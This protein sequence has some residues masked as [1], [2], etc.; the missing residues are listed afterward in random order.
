MH[1]KCAFL[2][3]DLDENIYMKQLDGYEVLR[4]KNLVYK[5]KKTIYGLKQVHRVSNAKIDG[6]FKRFKF[7]MCEIGHNI[8]I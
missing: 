6:F 2:N 4:C 8:Y 1:V 5:L 3:M 7:Q